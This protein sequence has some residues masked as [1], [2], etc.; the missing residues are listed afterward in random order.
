MV[1]ADIGERNS[2]I[3]VGN[4]N[5]QIVIYVNIPQG[6]LTEWLKRTVTEIHLVEAV[7]SVNEEKLPQ[8]MQA[9]MQNASEKLLQLPLLQEELSD[10]VILQTEEPMPWVYMATEP[11]THIMSNQTTRLETFSTTS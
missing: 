11:R 3:V 8:T 10:S 6:E 2:A 9:G 1:K 7:V 4:Y 5:V